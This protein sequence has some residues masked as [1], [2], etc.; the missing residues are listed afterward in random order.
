[1]PPNAISPRICSAFAEYPAVFFF[2]LPSLSSG[3]RK[4]EGARRDRAH[5]AA[6]ALYRAPLRARRT[7][8]ER[9]R[10][11]SK[12]HLTLTWGGVMNQHDLRFAGPMFLPY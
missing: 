9:L 5:Y 3:E 1:M 12:S 11:V 6:L 4:S 8:S 7:P 2:L 10:L